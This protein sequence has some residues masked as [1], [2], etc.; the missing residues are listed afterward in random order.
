MA[1]GDARRSRR[2]SGQLENDI[3]AVLWTADGPLSPAQV[4]AALSGSAYN[5]VHTILTRLVDKGQLTRFAENGRVGY[6]PV[7]GAAERAADRMLAA[8]VAGPGRAEVLSQFVTRMSPE[9]EAALRS[10][11]P[12]G[13]Q[14]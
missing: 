8:L 13:R 11:L 9:E 4:Q 6:S 5:T 12:Q 7:Q 1:I 3:L 2:A 10:V 14:R